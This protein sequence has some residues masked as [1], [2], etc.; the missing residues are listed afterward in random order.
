VTEPAARGRSRSA[1]GAL[2]GIIV[3]VAIATARVVVAGEAEL[4]ASTRALESG[5][6]HEAAV[7]A[8]AA[9]LWY[10]PGAPHVAVAY[11]R[12]MAIGRE[13]EKR[14]LDDVAL[15][16]YRAVTTASTSTRWAITPHQT[17]A[18]EARTA[19]ARI[20]GRSGER[21][22]DRVTDPKEAMERAQLEALAVDQAARPA[23]VAGL[24]VSFLVLLSGLGWVW[25]RA[26]DESGR[27]DWARARVATGIAGLGLIGYL[28]TWWAA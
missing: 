8:R 11:G 24:A 5:D 21:P 16:S 6:A 1:L 22:P 19:I 4:A 27:L 2:I 26:F 7:R 25:A 15:F 28:L 17:D 10:A 20:E 9:A 18:N 3:V 23:W 12:L 13:A 14:K